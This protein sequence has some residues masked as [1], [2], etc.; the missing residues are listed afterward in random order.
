VT[1]HLLGIVA[2]V[3]VVAAGGTVW[4]V[5]RDESGRHRTSNAHMLRGLTGASF[6]VVAVTLVFLRPW[7]WALALAAVAAGG[8]GGVRALLRVLERRPSP[9]GWGAIAAAMASVVLG[10]AL[11]T[12]GGASAVVDAAALVGGSPSPAPH[13]HQVLV[14]P[15]LYQLFWGPAWTAGTSRRAL[16]PAVAFQQGLAVSPWTEAV[17]GAGFGVRSLRAGGCWIDP[18]APAVPGAVV[19]TTTGPL[20]DE[21]RRAFSGHRR[22]L[23][24]PGAPARPVPTT[25]PVDALVAVWLDPAVP[26]TLGGV[27][28]H[29]AVPWPGHPDGVVVAA[30]S[31]GFADWG[32]PRCPAVAAC[33]AIPPYASPTYALSHEVVEAATNPFG[34]GWFAD[35]PLPWSARYFLSHGPSSLLGTAPV[36]EGE[37]AD[38][39]EPGQP[40]ARAAPP[41]AGPAR[42]PVAPF[43]RPGSGCTA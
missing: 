6:V 38:L 14:Q 32:G 1:G 40:D 29:G 31:G 24:C 10:S 5:V 25:L 33:R 18:R 42:L 8:V 19:G 26:D 28:A 4:L 7:Y 23:P 16:A 3:A 37:V 21:L 2:L 15:V 27:S 34:R 11:V 35:A 22:L 17:T 41:N 13:D 20:P 9:A 36:F 39:C 43:Y 30:L 12:L